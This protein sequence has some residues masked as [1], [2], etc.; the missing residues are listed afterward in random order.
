MKQKSIETFLIF[1]T[2]FVSSIT[3]FTTPFEGYFHYLIF[4]LFFPFFIFKYGF[5]QMPFKILLLPLIAGLYHISV[6]DDTWELFLK[7]FL[8]VLLSTSFY[9]YVF[10]YYDM[11]LERLF[12]LY[13]RGCVVVSWIGIVQWVSYKVGF[14]PGYDYNWLFNKWGLVASENGGLRVNSIFAEPAQF[15]IVLIPAVFIATQGLMTRSQTYLSS[16]QSFIVILVV[17][18]S[19]SSTGY[20]GFFVILLLL[21]MNYGHV[22][23]LVIGLGA[24]IILASIMYTSVPEF[25]SRVDSTIGLWVNEDLSVNNVN[26]SSFVL[27]NNFHIASENFKSN[28][29]TGTGLGSHKIAFDK[30][31][32]TR[33]RGFLLFE[34]NQ[35][36]ANSLLLRLMSETGL[37]GLIFILLLV[38]RCYVSR[39]ADERNEVSWIISNSILPML[40]LCMI[41][42][43]NYF[44]NGLPFF[45]MLYYYN[46]LDYKNKKEE[47][48]NIELEPAQFNEGIEEK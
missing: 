20:I 12:R 29:F 14:K 7:I 41:R 44:L 17:I 32:L 15:S 37:S 33:R 35:S 28:I 16:F 3:F 31:S 8:G 18:L 39:K 13:L 9:F 36:D 47:Y 5:P 10:K 34:N 22:M 46:Y 27:Y 45:F 24:I 42:Q 6:G 2:I 11:D 4:L 40:I 23:N 48:Q 30:Y 21:I 25:Q 26:S 1:T 43:G 19:T 38:F